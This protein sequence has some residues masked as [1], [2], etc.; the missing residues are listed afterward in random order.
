MAALTVTAVR[1]TANTEISIVNY[2]E[3]ISAGEVLYRAASGKHLKADADASALTKAA[4][5]LAMTP[6]V[7]NGQGVIATSGNV[8]LVGA[9]M[10]VGTTYFLGPTAGQIV[11]FGD[12]SSND[13]VTRLGTAK[14]ATELILSIEDTGVLVP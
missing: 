1:P 6:G 14:S 4:K 12:L 7:D 5:G 11:P 8:I 13:Y 2:G 10:S 3:T 9:T